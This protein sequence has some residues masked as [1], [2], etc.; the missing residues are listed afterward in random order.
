MAI[1]SIFVV[2]VMP[3]GWI[4]VVVA[5]LAPSCSSDQ[6]DGGYLAGTVDSVEA[7]SA[8]TNGG[9]AASSDVVAST[10]L[11]QTDETTADVLAAAAAFRATESNSFGDSDYFTTVYVVER[12]GE[13]DDVGFITFADTA[14]LI[15][16]VQRCAIEAALEPR[17]VVW[18]DGLEAVIGTE[19]PVTVPDR[20]AVVMLAEPV[21]DGPRAEVGTELWCGMVCGIGSTL[22]VERSGSGE[23]IV[24]GELGG[25]VS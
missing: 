9:V 18:V 24:T 12:L 16:D 6:T 1:G 5:G 7:T 20:H 22:V 23:W 8:A 2:G 21:I 4:F 10:Q 3:V 17:T 15:T 11:Q 19:P 14:P 13:A 25:F